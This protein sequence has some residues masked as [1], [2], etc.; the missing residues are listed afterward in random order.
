MAQTGS[1]IFSLS[2]IF[3]NDLENGRER[4]CVEFGDNVNLK[5]AESF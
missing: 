5:G 4:K 1:V 3:V 2:D